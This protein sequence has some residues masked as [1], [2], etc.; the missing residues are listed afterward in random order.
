MAPNLF[1]EIYSINKN[2]KAQRDFNKWANFKIDIRQDLLKDIQ[3]FHS[4]SGGNDKYDKF[5]RVKN[6]NNTNIFILESSKGKI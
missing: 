3:D 6:H 5:R 1:R 4:I 2:Q